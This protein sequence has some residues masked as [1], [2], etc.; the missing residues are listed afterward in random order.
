[1]LEHELSNF[2]DNFIS[3][4]KRESAKSLLS[5]RRNIYAI[6]N[7][8]DDV[9]RFASGEIVSLKQIKRAEE[10][11]KSRLKRKRAKNY[12][13]LYIKQ[14]KKQDQAWFEQCVERKRKREEWKKKQEEQNG[15]ILQTPVE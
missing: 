7:I 1:M 9:N 10:F 8:L 5:L 15:T 3:Y 4:Q 2:K 14:K 6:K 11:T 13:N 12:G